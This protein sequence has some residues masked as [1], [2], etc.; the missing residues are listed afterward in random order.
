MRHRGPDGEGIYLLGSVAL[1]VRR[2]SILDLSSTA[3]QPMVS[4]DGE[5][6]LC[7]NGEVYNYVELRKELQSCGHTFRSS[8][9]T[10]VLLHA[11]LEWGYDCLNR[12]NGMWAFLIYD[13]RQGKIFGSRDRFGKKPLYYYRAPEIVLIGSEIKA[14][15]ASGHYLGGIN[16]D[17]ASELLLGSGLHNVEENSYTF[18]SGINQ[19]QA[20]H[21]FELDLSGRFKQWCFWSLPTM[22][23][24]Q[25]Q[26]S[27]K[28][29]AENF[30]HIFENAC[31]L[32]MRSDAPM[33][34]LLSGGL[35]STSVL[36]CLSS[37]ADG[38]VRRTLPA[39]SYQSKEYDESKYLNDTIERTGVR[40]IQCNPQPQRLWDSLEEML[41]YQDEPVH[42]IGPV[43]AFDLYRLAS[44]CGVKVILTGGGADEFLGYPNLFLN[45]WSSLLKSGSV[46]SAWREI[47]AHCIV[48]GGG[49]RSFFQKSLIYL[50]KSE[51]RRLGIYRT[52]ASWRQGRQFR[53]NHW[54]TRELI[55]YLPR[56]KHPYQD[57]SLDAALRR[58]VLSAPLP[59]YLRVDDRN[60]MAHS[61]ESRAPLLDYRLISLA[62][63]LPDNWKMRGPWN[64]YLLREAMR[65]RIPESIENRLEKW[66]FPVPAR[67]WLACDLSERIQDLLG[68]RQT[69]ERGI[70]N[71]DRIRKDYELY[72]KGAAD[73]SHEL[74]NVVQ[75][76][77]WSKKFTSDA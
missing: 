56:Q 37:V 64:K 59:V 28:D 67:K 25:T 1:A 41:W 3:D 10:E 74:F 38:E 14:I 20:G 43:I 65:H 45:Y 39:F 66:G 49:A 4:P 69:R 63:Q 71:V 6:I 46:F 32:R 48:R 13:R 9:D 44:Q 8:G 21:A 30:Y 51:L 53:R 62:F 35:D 61:V 11:Y 26:D 75:F 2:L 42:S 60:S 77:L 73:I 57:P 16:W 76:E 29:P 5:V 33:G 27:A 17:K 58:S 18:F 72:R 34:I 23:D 31:S 22:K 50:V 36:C 40:L 47:A 15:L 19:L 52:L 54:F 68:S 55:E 7:F 70:Y 12:L 24:P